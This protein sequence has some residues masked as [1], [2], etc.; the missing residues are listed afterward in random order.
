MYC[1]DASVLTATFDKTDKF[2][3]KSFRFFNSAIRDNTRIIIP[4]LALA[5]LAGALARKGN[6]INDINE[7]LKLLLSLNNTE[8]VDLTTELCALSAEFAMQLKVKG[9]D[10]VYIAVSYEHN[11]K[12]VTNDN[13]QYERSNAIIEAITPEEWF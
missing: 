4:A 1:I 7:Y 13:Q 8:F 10:S 6:E 3:D 2:H 11:L 5:E 9:S 12:L